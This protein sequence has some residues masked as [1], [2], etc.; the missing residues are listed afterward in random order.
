MWQLLHRG[1][2]LQGHVARKRRLLSELLTL[3]RHWHLTL[4][5]GELLLLPRK[6]LAERSLLP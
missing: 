2:L 6:L 1:L 4:L 3:R 5:Q